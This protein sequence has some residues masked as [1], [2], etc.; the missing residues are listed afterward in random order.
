MKEWLASRIPRLGTIILALL[1]IAAT[2]TTTLAVSSRARQAPPPPDS[3]VRVAVIGDSYSAGVDNEVVWPSLIAAGSPLSIS[4]VAARDASYAGTAGRSGRFEDQVDKALASKPSVIVVFGGLGDAGLPDEQITQSATD[5]F[6]ELVRRAP[7]SKVVVLGPIWHAQPVPDVFVTLDARIGEAARTTQVT[8]IS[9]IGMD[10][11]AKDG[12]M[13]GD[14][15]PTDSG[16][17]A[18]A[19]YLNPILLQQIRNPS[20]SVLP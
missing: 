1:L 17:F 8:Y 5:L 20:R 9:L 6:A 18:L 16:Q 15:A 13:Q 2:A 7:R 12:L 19:R 10:W 11:L 3:L 4:V 14:A